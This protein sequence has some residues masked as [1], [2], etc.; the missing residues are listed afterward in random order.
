MALEDLIGQVLDEKY[1][2]EKQLGQGGM[3][4]VYLAT[5]LGTGRPVALKIIA[6]QLMMQDEFVER[7]RREAKAA[8]RLRHP[9]VVDVTD[10]GFAELGKQRAAYLVM[11][12]LDG[13]SLA[14][15]LNEESRL[16]LEWVLDIIEQT[17]SAVDEAHQQGI[18]HRDL[19]P[20]NI[21]LEPNRRGGYTVK[22]LDFGLAKLGEAPS[23]DLVPLALVPS[24]LSI[25]HSARETNPP[26]G[27]ASTMAQSP[28]TAV[29]ERTRIMEMATRIQASASAE[30]SSTRVLVSEESPAMPDGDGKGA[31]TRIL[32]SSGVLAGEAAARSEETSQRSSTRVY[33]RHT[34]R[35]A[36]DAAT[37]HDD[38]LTRVGS[39]MGTPVYMSP[40]QCRGEA[41]TSRSD[42][43]SLGVITYQLL[44]GRPPFTGSADEVMR[45]H[46]DEAPQPLRRLGVKIRK[47]TQQWV[48]AA[49]AKDPL[50]RPVSAA[51]FASALR[52]NSEGAGTLGRRT[53]A[54]FS[55]YVP[56]FLRVAIIVNL[57]LIL[58]TVARLGQQIAY[59]VSTSKLSARLVVAIAL[60]IVSAPVSFLTVATQSG[61]IVL[62]VTQLLAAPLRPLDPKLA[63][64]T[65]KKRWKPLAKTQILVMGMI[66]GGL[67]L[68][69]VPGIIFAVI[70]S[71]AYAVVVIEGLSGRA[72][73]KRSKTL[74]K[75]DLPSVLCTCFVSFIIPVTASLL[76]SVFLALLLKQLKAPEVPRL[77]GNL[78]S[79]I[80][81]PM[82]V[83]VLAIMSVL[84][85]LLYWKTRQAGG[86]TLKQALAQIEEGVPPRTQWQLRMRERAHSQANP[87][88]G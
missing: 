28:R 47:R 63:A 15:I 14:A 44:A 59:P 39:I 50:E 30:E 36:A 81:L 49:L 13:C 38:G 17:C 33:A 16:P 60:N 74:V 26:D 83:I 51:A 85:S 11:E 6:P 19:K 20:D 53:F 43:Y 88:G 67:V 23:G 2:I 1:H 64:A 69:L 86:E 66:L 79:L 45:A 71:L 32:P 62:L 73:L 27:A 37:V 76:I 5:H 65:L 55:E 77:T 87:L 70:F 25:E 48:S 18:I 10:F 42:I 75:R 12:Y 21:W 54:I 7:F 29:V 57:P 40:E 31:A 34:L 82:Q 35:G 84:S 52:A 46:L 41:I 8:G 61:I 68:A 22:V 58:L 3:G 72:A 9:N 4:A 78:T 80:W 24:P 56:T